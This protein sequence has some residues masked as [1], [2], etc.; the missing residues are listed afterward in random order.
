VAGD[1]AE[2]TT[3]PFLQRIQTGLE[4]TD[5]GGE[6][7]IALGELIVGAALRRHRPLQAIELAYTGLRE[8][9]PVLQEDNDQSQAHGEPFHGTD[10]VPDS[11]SGRNLLG[12]P[13]LTFWGTAYHRTSDFHR[14]G[15]A[16]GVTDF[17][18]LGLDTQQLVVLGHAIGA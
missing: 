12:A 7:A 5:F 11:V 16:T 2:I 15:I 1:H 8:P 18:Q 4:I 6:L 17:L 10:S 13:N 3:R 14:E 9:N